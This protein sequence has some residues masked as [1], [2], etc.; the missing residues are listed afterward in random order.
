MELRNKTI[1]IISQ[2]DWGEMFISKHHY[3]VELAKRGN[4]IFYINFPDR[5]HKFKRGEIKITGT[6]YESIKVVEHRLLFPYF[7]KYRYTWLYNFLIGFHIR[8]ILRKIGHR[9]DIVWSFDLSNAIPLHCFPGKPLKIFMPVDE[10]FHAYSIAAAK[11]AD[12]ILSVTN[13]ILDRYR[14]FQVPRHFVNHGVAE[15]FISKSISLNSNDP[16]RIGYSGGLLRKEIDWPTFFC[17][18]QNNP[19][20]IFDFW[21]EYDF[22]KSFINKAR[23]RD[24]GIVKNIETLK[25]FSNTRLH[26][27]MNAVK[28]FDAIKETDA[29]IICYDIQKDQSHGTNYHKILEYLG[30]GKVIIANN[31]S[32]YWN[33]FPGMLQMAASRENNQEMPALFSSVIQNLAVHNAAEQQQERINFAKQFVYANQVN[34]IETFLQEIS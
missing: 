6:K 21:G 33:H 32:T 10:P 26:G 27:V 19:D 4:K 24:E 23:N 22:D 13:E 18:I 11:S 29:L 31:V 34:K 17:I 3:A 14:D 15:Y 5:D 9:P 8:R 12:I 20:K 25:N 16:I 28:L 1:V 7:F 30:T 2:E